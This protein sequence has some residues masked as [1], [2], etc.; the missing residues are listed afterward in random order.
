MRWDAVG[1]FCHRVQK[2]NHLPPGKQGSGRGGGGGV[3]GFCHQVQR[4]NHLVL[5]SHREQWWKWPTISERG[6]GGRWGRDSGIRPG[7]RL[8]INLIAVV[9]IATISR[10]AMRALTPPPLPPTPQ[11]PLKCLMCPE[12]PAYL[13]DISLTKAVS[14]KYLR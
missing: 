5:E 7:T 2:I 3:G 1:G 9:N 11:G 8:T 6:G 12:L 10:N 13:G 14:R 4:N